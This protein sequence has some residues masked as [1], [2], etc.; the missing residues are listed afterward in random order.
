MTDDALINE[1]RSLRSDLD[2]Y[3]DRVVRLRL[4]DFRG[5]FIEQIRE[6]LAQEGRRTFDV[7]LSSVQQRADCEM[8]APCQKQLSEMMEAVI[9]KLQKDDQV[10]AVALL[11]GVV[12]LI[13]GE[14]TPCKDAECSKRAAEALR[15]VK[16]ILSIY[17]I[18]RSRLATGADDVDLVSKAPIMPDPDQVEKAI[19]PL[20]NAWRIRILRMLVVQKRTLTEIG[21]SLSMKTGHLQFHMRSLMSAGYVSSDRRSRLYS[22]TDKGELALRGLDEL[23]GRLA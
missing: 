14:S 16:A 5:M 7:D 4:E 21:R 9:S 13:C 6:I 12:G 23:M 2:N 22:L 3:S 20:S 11:D 8:R 18:L 17:F 19:G 1:L 10:G 15:S